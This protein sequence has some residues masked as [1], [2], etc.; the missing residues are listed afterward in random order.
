L[1]INVVAQS[2]IEPLYSIAQSAHLNTKNIS[3]TQHYLGINHTD[4]SLG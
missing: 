4:D 1:E 3:H 2:H